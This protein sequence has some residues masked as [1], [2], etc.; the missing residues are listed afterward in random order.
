MDRSCWKTPK[1]SDLEKEVTEC[2]MKWYRKHQSLLEDGLKG[3]TPTH[4]AAVLGYTNIFMSVA[5]YS[6]DINA[7]RSDG[8]TPLHITVQNGSTEIFKHLAPQVANPNAPNPN[9]FT[10]LQAA[11]RY[12]STEIFQFLAPQVKNPNAPI[13]DG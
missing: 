6:K 13:P 10:P 5:S 4:I 9:G 2:L 7:P 8:F 3:M 11:A 12:G 1:G